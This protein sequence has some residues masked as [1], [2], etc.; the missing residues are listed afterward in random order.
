MHIERCWK[1]YID[2][3]PVITEIKIEDEDDEDDEIGTFETLEMTIEPVEPM[4]GIDGDVD[5][6]DMDMKGGYDSTSDLDDTGEYTIVEASSKKI[7]CEHCDVT[8]LTQ[9]ELRIHQQKFHPEVVDAP[10]FIC[11]ICKAR[12]SSRYG[13]RTHMT[14]HMQIGTSVR[15]RIKHIKRY[16]CSTCAERFNKKADLVEH[17]L[18]HAG[19]S[20]MFFLHRFFSIYLAVVSNQ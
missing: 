7:D 9:A 15:E 13:I 6:L 1:Q 18:R 2:E 8:D 10:Q 4:S 5:Y 12:Y 20:S 3:I 19:V 16:Q 17:E 11:D 14:R